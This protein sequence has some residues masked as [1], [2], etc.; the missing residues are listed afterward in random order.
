[1][2]KHIMSPE[3]YND[4]TAKLLSKYIDELEKIT[5]LSLQ[6]AV[7]YYHHP[8]LK[9]ITNDDL[10]YPDVMIISPFHGIL[11]FKINNDRKNRNNSFEWVDNYL[12][13]LETVIFS[14]LIKSKSKKLKKSKR[15]LLFP[16]VSFQFAPYH[17]ENI[18][19]LNLDND[20]IENKVQLKT[21]FKELLDEPLK[22]TQIQ[23]I[24]AIIE[25]TLGL[26]N[27][28]DR[29]YSG[30]ISSK[31]DILKNLEEE[32]AT[33]DEIQKY[34]AFS[35]LNGPQ[36]IRGLAGSGK[37]VILCLKAALLHLKYP[38]KKILY[39]FMTKSLYDFIENLI[40]KFY[41]QIGD[42]RLPDLENG[43]IIRHAWGGKNLKGVYSDTCKTNNVIPVTFESAMIRTGRENAFNYI[44][45]Q[46]LKETQGKLIK[47]YDYVLIDEAQDFKPSFYQV[48]REIVKNDC[49]VWG[50]DDLQNIF[51]VNL[52]N[53]MET[54]GN[55]YGSEGINLPILQ[56]NHPDLDNDIV[57]S[58]CYRNPKEI[59]VLAHSIGFGIYNSNLIQSL[60]NSMHWRDLGYTVLEGNCTNGSQMKIIRES[61]NS[62]LTISTLQT[63]GQLIEKFS[64][65]SFSLEIDWVCTQIE[66]AIQEDNLRADDISVVCLDDRHTKDYFKEISEKLKNKS[67]YT[68]NLSV[69]NYEKGYYKENCI[70]LST[71]YKAK[72]NEAGM[73]FVIGCDV[74]DANKDSKKMRNKTFTAFTRTKAWLRISGV[75]WENGSLWSEI[76]DTIINDFTLNF[77]HKDA[78]MI[79][80]D[81]DE[82][83]ITKSKVREAQEEY[84][85]KLKALNLSEIEIKSLS[86]ENINLKGE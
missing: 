49:L 10:L 55:N 51:N 11:L 13:Q 33:F 84:I 83:N 56:Q 28:K 67:I 8:L 4:E 71:V 1:M 53:T 15:E 77:V 63:P 43:I 6:D 9:E 25:S 39:T 40:T 17:E 64:A 19:G 79:M 74:F 22:E 86:P 7:F 59:L 73:I 45:E 29:N 23:E 78:G 50:Y 62:P 68:N 26:I 76:E 61:K 35:Q 12:N 18:D 70:T 24:Y 60:E 27:T 20:I 72:G 34:A 36:R 44:C 31:A 75:K 30:G 14:K 85:K 54:F 3:F 66:K 65:E 58:K 81:L 52:Q 48:C 21:L 2:E 32:I 46:L 38:E 16:L 41:K 47:Q 5:E 80:R 57:L 42:G 69:T 82:V 37:T